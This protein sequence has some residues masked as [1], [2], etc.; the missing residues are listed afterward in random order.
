[1]KDKTKSLYTRKIQIKKTD[2]AY[3]ELDQ[4][5][6]LSKNLYNTCRYIER[7]TFFA[8]RNCQDLEQKKG[9]KSFLN[10]F[11]LSKQFQDENQVDHRA[12]PSAVSQQN[13]KYR[14]WLIL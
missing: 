9:M 6:F 10:N 2:Q 7:Q 3:K 4:M 8:K 11:E 1:M 14:M 12:L 13:W 5:M